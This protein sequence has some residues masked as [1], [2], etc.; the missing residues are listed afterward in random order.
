[1]PCYCSVVCITFVCNYSNDFIVNQ[2]STK[3]DV[4]LTILPILLVY[5]VDVS[6]VE[7]LFMNHVFSKCWFLF[8][9]FLSPVVK[10]FVNILSNR[11]VIIHVLHNVF[12]SILE[13]SCL[14]CSFFI[15]ILYL[16][17]D[18]QIFF[19]HSTCLLC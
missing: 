19:V 15:L 9:C 18:Q 11:P 14:V 8:I 16:S 7:Y 6:F 12:L 10:T 13:I 17:K 5:Y 2:C 4:V 3:W 1:M